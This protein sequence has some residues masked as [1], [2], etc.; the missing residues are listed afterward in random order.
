MTGYRLRLY[1]V[2]GLQKHVPYP[3]CTVT[4][5]RSRWCGVT[6]PSPD[7]ASGNAYSLNRRAVRHNMEPAQTIDYQ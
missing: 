5:Y 3:P 2:P 6:G 7:A 4:A 1:F